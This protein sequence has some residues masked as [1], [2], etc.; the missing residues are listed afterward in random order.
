LKYVDLYQ[1][2][3]SLAELMVFYYH[4]HIAMW[5]DEPTGNIR[6][7]L[8]VA[9]D[10]MRNA[11]EDEIHTRLLERLR[12]LVD[13]DKDLKHPEWLKSPGLIEAEVE[14]RRRQGQELYDN[15]TSGQNGELGSL[16]ALP[17]RVISCGSCSA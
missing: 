3:I 6:T 16:L 8:Q 13:I 15:L 17:R 14:A 11:S 1:H 4:G 12:A 7:D 2:P 9:I 10:Q 5:V